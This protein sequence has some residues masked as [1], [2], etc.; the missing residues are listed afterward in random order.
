MRVEF[1]GV[2]KGLSV[3]ATESI[4]AVTLTIE[5]RGG[6]T[7]KAQALIDTMSDGSLVISMTPVQ[8]SLKFGEKPEGVKI[9]THSDKP[10]ISI[11]PAKIKRVRRKSELKK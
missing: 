6:L 7:Q 9:E 4:P 5:A 1:T 10:K 11:S 8:S 3:K 2:I